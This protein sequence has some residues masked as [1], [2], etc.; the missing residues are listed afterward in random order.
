MLHVIIQMG[1]TYVI[2]AKDMMEM[3]LIALVCI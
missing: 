1:H 3:E 2:V